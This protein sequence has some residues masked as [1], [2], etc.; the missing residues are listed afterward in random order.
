V[1]RRRST[2]GVHAVNHGWISFVL[3]TVAAT[4]AQTFP[5]K[6]PQNVVYQTSIVFLFAA[7]LV[8][9]PELLVL[10]PLVMTIPEWL[11]QRYPVPIEMSN[12]AN[13]T[14]S[15]LAAWG[16][17][18]L[19]RFHE[20]FISASNARFAVAGLAASGAFVL[21]NHVIVASRCTSFADTISRRRASSR[22]TASRSIS[23][24]PHSGSASPPSGSGIPGLR[25]RRSRLCSSCTAR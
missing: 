6:S 11:R 7:A 18:D 2:S 8:L 3:L 16:M 10:I 21:A 14:L 15:A 5:V 25:S 22:S 12:V 24:S 13:Y 19:V 17:A 23:S 20:T 1:R 9:P 4:V